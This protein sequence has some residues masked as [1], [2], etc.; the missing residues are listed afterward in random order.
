M[1]KKHN[2]IILSLWLFLGPLDQWVIH[3]QAVENSQN[4][5][6]GFPRVF[7]RDQINIK[8]PQT[9]EEPA[10]GMGGEQPVVPKFPEPQSRPNP[11][12]PPQ[13]DPLLRARPAGRPMQAPPIDQD[14][15]KV[16]P[17][18]CRAAR[19]EFI[20]NFEN[21]ALSNVL[22][23]AADLTCRNITIPK[24]V[25]IDNIKLTIIGKDPIGVNDAWDILLKSLSSNGFTLNNRKK[26][27]WWELESR[28]EMKQISTPFYGRGDQ[29]EN[30]DGVGTLFYR[31][32]HVSPDFLKNT[33]K[34]LV[35]KEALVDV[36]GDKFILVI[37]SNSNL[38]RIQYIID[39]VDKEE[40]ASK[41]YIIKL[42]HL[43][44]KTLEQQLLRIFEVQPGRPR[45]R[46]PA[47]AESIEKAS[48]SIE[49]IIAFEDKIILRADENGYNEVKNIVSVLDQASDKGGTSKIHVIRLKYASAKEV[50]QTLNDVVGAGRSRP[51]FGPP[52]RPEG[53]GNSLFEGEVKVTAHEEA[54]MLVI[55][56]SSADYPSILATI[57]KLDARRDQV[58]L[59]VAILE[60]TVNDS[61]NLGMDIFAGIPEMSG[62]GSSLGVLANP[63][64]RK[65]AEGLV[66][67]LKDGSSAASAL[68]MGNAGAGALAMLSSFMSGG[69]L[70]LVGSPSAGSSIPSFGVILKAISTHSSVDVIATPSAATTD[71]KE[72]VLKVGE[73]V[74]VIKGISSVASGA[75]GSALN[76]P[77]QNT[78]YEDVNLTLK[79]TPHVGE[80]RNIKLDIEQE[81]NE[82]GGKHDVG[83]GLTQPVIKTQ[84][85][86]TTLVLKD[87]ETGVIGGLTSHRTQR[88]DSKTPFLGDI[89][90]LGWLFKSRETKNDK[91]NL[92]IAVTPY[93]IRNPEDS[94][95]IF[96]KKMKERD[97]FAKL[98][99][100]GKIRNYNPHV[101][102]DRKAGPLGSLFLEIEKEMDKR[103]N[104]GPGIEDDTLIAPRAYRK[105]APSSSPLPYMPQPVPQE[106][107]RRDINE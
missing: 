79:I 5:P 14:M 22:K 74:P 105:P 78:T 2:F 26:N 101:D 85:A 42:E 53:E 54:N 51:R 99:Y 67:T 35:S 73:K 59:E 65:I 76:M 36:V 63:G 47:G 81:K 52:R 28:Q 3:A 107:Y 7:G 24:T 80:D 69:A 96:E 102:Y 57:E 77:M 1:K 48:Y 37:D 58:Y 104:F 97:E 66:G 20:W 62:I 31:T 95:N 91:K 25:N 29:A 18:K 75:V 68:N 106:D 10:R 87:Q 6:P 49:N 72:V 61:K 82:L 45:A 90:L 92:L 71:N 23:Q 64:G 60:I 16:I 30:N 33:A 55:T 11:F 38:R 40:S 89:P 93:L 17:Q 13:A 100:G 98:Y 32:K 83:N 34:N 56:A 94:R 44:G 41:I 50:A 46:R 15:F 43:E 86:K 8:P 19:G 39:E 84:S 88:D 27:G 12:R 70:G 103:E 9:P 21:E 4:F